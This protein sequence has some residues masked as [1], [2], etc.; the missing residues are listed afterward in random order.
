MKT[1]TFSQEDIDL[2]FGATNQPKKSL[3]DGLNPAQT[4]G[5][6]TT[7][8]PVR[9]MAGAGSGK[10]S[11]IVKRIAYIVQEKLARPDQILAVTF[12]RKAAAE[13]RTRLS[14]LLGH[15]AARQVAAGNFH[16]LSAQMLRRHAHLVGLPSTFTILD[17]DGQRDVI[18]HLG[19]A[20]GYISTVKDKA[21]IN[22]FHA[23]IAAWKADGR[24]VDTVAAA[25]DLV[26]ISPGPNEDE[27]D[28][29]EQ[30]AKLMRAYQAE[31][32]A[33]R[34]CDF[35]DLVLNMV[36]IFRDHPDVLA[37]EASR[38]LYI[39][40][41][42]FQD[43][44]PTQYEWIMLMA[45]A[46]SNICVVGD[47][48]QSIYEWRNARPDIMLNFPRDWPGTK[49]ITIDMN[50]RSTQQ[51]LDVANAVV[52]PLREKDGLVKKL[53]S[54]KTGV[55]P[56]SF[57]RIYENGAEE[58]DTIADN[59]RSKIDRGEA[60]SEIAVL[61]R[62]G[63]I[64]TGIERALRER[65]MRY[66]VA[67]A[68]KFTDREEIK[69]VVAW[70]TLALNPLDYV[71]FTRVSKKPRRGIGPQKIGELRKLMI[72]NAWSLGDAARALADA[73][74][75]GS[76][77]ARH[78]GEL[79]ETLGAI[80]A[81]AQ[82]GD[83]VGAMLEDILDETGYLDWRLNNDTDPVRDQRVENIEQFIDEA[84]GY[85]RIV[86]F[87]EMVALQAATDNGFDEDAI[88]ISTVHASK[89]LEFNTVYCP[90]MEDG[91]FPNARS[92]RTRYGEDEE[93]RIAHVAW[94]RARD[95]LHVSYAGFRPG[96]NGIAEPSPYLVEAGLIE[97]ASRRQVTKRK[98]RRRQ[99]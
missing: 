86:D 16:A 61:C 7:E 38:F 19:L 11:T 60:P 44:D 72:E 37:E 40:V 79:A 75:P 22:K 10:T 49:E 1:A 39:L 89:G 43:T 76:A 95:E 73:A 55:H 8:G 98:I 20:M 4:E 13:M 30:A 5:V 35:A 41:D 94:T 90:A 71:A 53:R 26:E 56:R 70:L 64:I 6:T 92:R 34:W 84:R 24:D 66:I 12:T 46:H 23:Q 58:A 21:R 93:R 51:I 54:N 52:A 65:G 97:G 29:L 25:T 57:M 36:R 3:L 85:A 59:I 82:N 42:E 88:V 2:A 15:D 45:R 47:T 62:S 74:R 9:I 33:R 63:M 80:E 31:L 68:M 77:N 18:S 99:F 83:N 67:G 81:V 96:G 91:I 17:D 48:D 50:Y 78:Y 14:G 27:P 32:V 28:F 69:D 87:L